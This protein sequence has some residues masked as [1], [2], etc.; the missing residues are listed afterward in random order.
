MEL[1][2]AEFKT[3]LLNKYMCTYYDS[4]FY[5]LIIHLREKSYTPASENIY[6]MLA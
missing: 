2:L 4:I 6:K 5:C 1:Y 3:T